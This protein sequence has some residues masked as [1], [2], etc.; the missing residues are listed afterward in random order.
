MTHCYTNIDKT[1]SGKIPDITHL[2]A[3]DLV[4]DCGE[5]GSL[6]GNESG[7]SDQGSLNGNGLGY[8]FF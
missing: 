3:L 4:S 1:I 5:L 7:I 6:I 2:P 8:G